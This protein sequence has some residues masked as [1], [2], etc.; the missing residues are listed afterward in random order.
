MSGLDFDV[1]KTTESYP[2]LDWKVVRV[3]GIFF[4]RR[5]PVEMS[6]PEGRLQVPETDIRG[7]DIS[8]DVSIQ[9]RR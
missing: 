1:W 7:E 6:A 8:D 3:P 5:D 4:N 9:I 2:T